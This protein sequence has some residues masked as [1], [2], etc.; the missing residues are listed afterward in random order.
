MPSVVFCLLSCMLILRNRRLIFQLGFLTVLLFSSQVITASHNLAGQITATY[1]GNNS[2]EI[3]LTT[4]TDPAPAGVDRCSA[5]IEIWSTGAVQQLIFTLENI[6]RANG[7]LMTTPPQDCPIANPRNGVP[8]YGTVKKNIYTATYTFPG[9]GLYELRYYDVARREDV[10]NMADPGSTAFF[11]ETQIFLPVPIVGVNNTPVLLNDPLDEACAGKLWT[12]NPGGFDPDGDSLVFTLRQSFQYEPPQD[13]GKI[14]V[15]QY[16][17]PDDPNAFDNGPLTMDPQTGLM[18]WRVPNEFGT[19]NIAYR[20]D[21][22]RNGVL[23]G[24]VVRDM[25][26]FVQECDNDPPV[27]QTI[28]EAC[29]YA[30]DTLSFP[31]KSWDPNIEDSLYLELNN[32]GLGDNG[33]F[34]DSLTNPARVG[35]TIF[36]PINGN[37]PW[38]NLPTST[39]NNAPFEPID[40]I[41][42]EIVWTTIC[43]NIRTQKY[44]VDFFAHDNDSYI[45]SPSNVRLA[46]NEVVQIKVVPPPATEL[47]ATKESRL[48]SLNWNP[49]ECDNALGYRVYRRIDSS[50]WVQDTVCCDT[51]PT[52]A[53]YELIAYQEGWDNIMYQ[54]SLN[55]LEGIF[56]KNICYVVTAM[57]GDVSAPS[58][59]LIESCATMEKCVEILNDTLFMTNDSVSTTSTASGSIFLSWSLPKQIDSFFPEPYTFH[60]FRGNHGEEADS[61]IAVVPFTDTTYLDTGFD[62]ESQGYNYRIEVFDANDLQIRMSEGTNEASSIFLQTI[63]GNNIISLSWTEF[64]P[65]QNNFYEVYRAD[66]GGSFALIDTVVSTPSNTHSYIDAGLDPALEYCYFIRSF[67]SYNQSGVKPLLI[68]DSQIACTIAQDT[69][70]PCNPLVIAQGDCESLTHTVQIIKN[71]DL[72]EDDGLEINVFFA[73]TPEAELQEILSIGYNEFGEDTTLNFSFGEDV[74]AFAGCYAVSSVDTLGNI[75][76]LSESFCIDFCPQLELG[77]VFSPNG[78]NVNDYFTPIFYRDVVLKEFMVFDRWGRLVHENSSDLEVLWNGEISFNN[79]MASDG[80]YYFYIKYEE[81]GIEMN[82]PKESKGWVTLIR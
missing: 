42:G 71:L 36:D 73:P 55:D 66:S 45:Q 40:T 70:P 39:E 20:V 80:V 1:I 14:P 43:D 5:D 34:S 63:P 82:T 12:H 58:V 48:I 62:T 57:Y 54:D 23:L 22:Y 16:R 9:P 8:I 11:V 53:G 59:P 29:V 47:T 4:Y 35:G 37:L 44:Q 51:N 69:F 74:E 10:V 38:L 27:I 68:N 25:A 61:M 19:Y 77:N 28:E 6:P 60:L 13:I 26:I 72:C 18:I 75:S 33:P 21:E 67:G 64:V 30:G 76:Q 52:Q 46:A 50:G 65:W 3:T 2:Y 49:S 31:V 15:N 17:F 7:V 79:Q 81:L 41:Q 32:A 24:Y 78:D 56:D